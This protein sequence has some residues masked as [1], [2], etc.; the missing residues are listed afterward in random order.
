MNTR[1]KARHGAAICA[2]IY[3]TGEF[4]GPKRLLYN[5][6]SELLT[7]VEFEE[8]LRFIEEAGCM[9]IDGETISLTDKGVDF[10]RE[11]SGSKRLYDFA[12]KIGQLPR[13]GQEKLN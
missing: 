1:D 10:S 6:I 12:K 3:S 11:F 7:P 4:S 8:V 13:R 9:T 2:M 5:T